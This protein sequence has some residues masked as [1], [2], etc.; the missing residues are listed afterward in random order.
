[1]S[2]PFIENVQE[3]LEFWTLAISW[4]GMVNRKLCFAHVTLLFS[5]VSSLKTFIA[6]CH[7]CQNFQISSKIGLFYS[8]LVKYANNGLGICLEN[9]DIWKIFYSSH[10]VQSRRPI[11][12]WKSLEQ[13][14][15]V[16]K[17]RIFFCD[18]FLLELEVF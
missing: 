6:H 4:Q 18:E 7:Y 2:E 8:T 15:R 17:V 11:I 16:W 1:M 13:F 12:F 5:S 9:S 14:M 3:T 10:Q